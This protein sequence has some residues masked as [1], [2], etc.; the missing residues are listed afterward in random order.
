M[1]GGFL[2]TPGVGAPGTTGVVVLVVF[3]GSAAVS[4]LLCDP[5][6]SGPHAAI[7]I[8]RAN[9]KR[10]VGKYR[11][12][13]R[14]GHEIVEVWGVVLGVVLGVV[15]GVVGMVLGSL[16]GWAQLLY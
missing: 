13:E 7:R 8:A 14:R 10:A 2:L 5:S 6:L 3:V 15:A 4:W 9:S 12:L 11:P 16:L 1:S